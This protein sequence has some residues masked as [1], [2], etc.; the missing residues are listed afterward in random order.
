MIERYH[1]N[2]SKFSCTKGVLSNLGLKDLADLAGEL[3][4]IS[5]DGDLLSIDRKKNIL[6]ERLSPILN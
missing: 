5:E 4:K 1:K 3:A 2:L 6:L